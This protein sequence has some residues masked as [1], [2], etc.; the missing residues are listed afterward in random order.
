ML[1]EPGDVPEPVPGLLRDIEP[2]P[3]NFFDNDINR[4]LMPRL[5]DAI[6]SFQVTMQCSINGTI[7]WVT[8]PRT[9]VLIAV[10]SDSYKNR[11]ELDARWG[12]SA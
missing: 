4:P 7:D 10:T 1:D 11:G 6:W 5:R 8:I 12:S 2:K 3:V 9:K